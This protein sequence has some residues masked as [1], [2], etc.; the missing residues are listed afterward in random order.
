MTEE[1][2]KIS[3]LISFACLLIALLLAFIRFVKGPTINDRIA[4]MDLIASIVIGFILIYSVFVQNAVY[5]DI[6]IVIALISFVGTVAISTYL[7][8]KR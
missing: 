3:A 7:K 1:I 6:A 8:Q 4:A 5:I 2:L